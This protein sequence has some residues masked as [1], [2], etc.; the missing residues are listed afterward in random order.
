MDSKITI[1]ILNRILE[2]NIIMIIIKPGVVSNIFKQMNKIPHRF[3]WGDR[4]LL[5]K[6]YHIYSE[7]FFS[8]CLVFLTVVIAR[9]L[10][11]A[12]IINL[13]FQEPRSLGGE[14]CIRHHH[15]LQEQQQ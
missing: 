7:R 1:K 2:N 8:Y 13:N 9:F 5:R 3:F 6:K 12:Q 10:L 15:H 14:V 11:C 4:L